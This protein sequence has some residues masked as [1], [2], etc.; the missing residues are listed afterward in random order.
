MAMTY[1]FKPGERINEVALARR[2]EVSR[3][4]LREAL[5]RLAAEGFLTM[6]PNR[7]FVGRMLDATEI[8]QLYEFRCEIE[9][10]IIRLACERATEE[11]LLDL[12]HFVELSRALY[13]PVEPGL[14]DAA[15]DLLAK[16]QSKRRG[17]DGE[18]VDFAFVERRARAMVKTYG[19]DV[20]GPAAIEVRE[21]LPAG[22]LV[23]GARLLISRS[24]TMPKSRVDALLSHEVGVHLLTY[25]NG[26]AQGLNLFRNGLAGY[27]G[28]QEGLAVFA[29]Y[30]AG[31]MTV[32]RLRLLAARV[33]GCADM[34]D[35]ASLPECFARMREFG[36]SPASA[37]NLVLRLYR[38]GGLAKDAIYLRGLI[39]I[40][41]HLR[42]G[43]ALDPFFMGKIAASH[44]SI[45][46]ELSTRGLIKPP[47]FAPQ[48][49]AHPEAQE[50]LAAASAGMS[51]IDMIKT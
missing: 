2:L 20:E 31:G 5:N 40:L 47:R 10:T 35:G 36:L 15:K 16:T 3:T 14:L 46:Q 19:F 30:L 6:V 7:G 25:F 44:F 38:G 9:E 23:S 45:M 21:D 17:A 27:E 41:A 42:A 28:I 8:Y 26:S 18:A 43:G 33:I 11:E 22:L 1:Q 12:E 29:E 50:R 34:L 49:L 24:T 32:T 13:G 39:E 4:P 37:F 51:P 48:F